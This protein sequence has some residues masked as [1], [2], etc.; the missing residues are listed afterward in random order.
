[1]ACTAIEVGYAKKYFTLN[2]GILTL[3]CFVS[4]SVGIEPI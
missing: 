4:A 1:M 2:V 3:V